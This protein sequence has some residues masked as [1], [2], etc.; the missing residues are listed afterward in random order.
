[1]KQNQ[2][3]A[4]L[5][6]R[7]L[8]GIIFFMQGYGKIFK[9]GVDKVFN[10]DFFYPTYKD[11]LPGFIIRVT[12]YYTSYVELIGGFLL[13]LGYKRDW[14]LY[15][16]ASVL[17]IVSFGHGLAEPIWDMTH[18]IFRAM[19]LISLLIIPKDWDRYSLDA[20]LIKR[21]THKSK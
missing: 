18:V 14:A 21:N 7:L 9:W 15:G 6:T 16:L 20:G 13:I 12:A 17:I 4:V 3:I 11:L 2:S 10:M 19:L 1:M 5:F 8:L